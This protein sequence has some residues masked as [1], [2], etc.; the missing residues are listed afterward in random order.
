VLHAAR[1]K[2]RTQKIV[3]NS[4]FGHHRTLC[5]PVSSQLRHVLTIGKNLVNTNISSTC[6]HNIMNF[7]PLPAEI[8]WQVWGTTADFN[9]F[10]V[11]DSLLQRYCS[12]EANHILHDVW[13]SPGPVHC[14]YIF[15][16]SCPVTEFCQVQ[17]S[18]CVQVLLS[19]MLA[20]LLHGT[21]APAAGV[22]QTLRR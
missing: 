10:H 3:K 21:P 1:W 9:G 18:L 20:A 12:T 7:G 16:G 11:L 22:G 5:R 17:N 4:P 19:P 14:I 2:Y 8:Y 13:P 15:G 6:L